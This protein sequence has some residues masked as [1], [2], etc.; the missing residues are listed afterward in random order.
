MTRL[1]EH[2]FTEPENRLSTDMPDRL[3]LPG[4]NLPYEHQALEAAADSAMRSAWGDGLWPKVDPI[5][6][7]RT[8][9]IWQGLRAACVGREDSA[10]AVILLTNVLANQKR[11]MARL[12]A[13]IG[14]GIAILAVQIARLAGIF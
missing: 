6:N 2:E 5:S 7:S 8:Y 3:R 4:T 10:T 1:T 12:N 11:V 13:I 14:I 9:T